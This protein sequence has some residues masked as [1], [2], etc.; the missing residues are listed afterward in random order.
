MVLI[1]ILVLYPTAQ[2]FAEGEED[3]FGN[4]PAIRKNGAL[5][6]LIALE[7]VVGF[8]QALAHHFKLRSQP[9]PLV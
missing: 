6:V 8:G 9:K 5:S 2:G 3:A 1:A 4:E 7:P